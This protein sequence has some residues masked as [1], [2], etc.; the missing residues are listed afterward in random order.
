MVLEGHSGIVTP[1]AFSPDG[2]ADH[3]MHIVTG[4]E[5]TLRI[6]A[7]LVVALFEEHIRSLTLSP[8]DDDILDATTDAFVL[9][10]LRGHKPEDRTP[11]TELSIVESVAFSPDGERIVSGSDDGTLRVW[12]ARTGALVTRPFQGHNDKVNSVSFSPEGGKIVSGPADHTLRIWD[13]HLDF[14]AEETLSD[15]HSDRVH[16]DART[17]ALVAGPLEGHSGAYV[18]PSVSRY[19][20]DIT[21]AKMDD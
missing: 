13:M 3:G 12:D 8:A 15:G 18:S 2:G 1:V 17:G 21:N 20:C 9:G 14:A 10:P 16:S 5:K 6:W 7:V 11:V 4:S 19:G